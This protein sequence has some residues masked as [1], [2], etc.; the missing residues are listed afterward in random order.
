MD[1]WNTTF[2]LGR[3]IFRGENVSF[4]EGNLMTPVFQPS[5]MW[6]NRCTQYNWHWAIWDIALHSRYLLC[7]R[8]EGWQNNKLIL[9]WK[10]VY[11]ISYYGYKIISR[12]P[13][14]Y[15]YIHIVCVYI[16]KDI[17]TT[18]HVYHGSFLRGLMIS[19][20]LCCWVRMVWLNIDKLCSFW[21]FQGSCR[22]DGWNIEKVG[23]A[24]VQCLEE[25]WT[26]NMNSQMVVRLMVKKMNPMGSNP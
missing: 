23:F 1:G 9:G 24:T 18:L 10:G 14:D 2:L 25:L 8:V 20:K 13:V 3:P 21:S 17:T 16:Y 15:Y 7:L 11:E 19:Q 26:K 6:R 12:L 5:V 4:R 22:W